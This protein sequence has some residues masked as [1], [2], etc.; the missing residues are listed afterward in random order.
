MQKCVLMLTVVVVSALAFSLAK[1]TSEQRFDATTKTCRTLTPE[2]DLQ[3]YK[4]FKEFCKDC[5]NKNSEQAGFLYNESKT[6]R[7]WDRVFAQKYSK[8][9]KDGSWKNMNL[10]DQLVLNDYLYRTGGDTY[11]PNGCG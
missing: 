8:C 4:L 6:P 11:A 3:G 2:R 7:A 1:A 9:A 5:H 10:D